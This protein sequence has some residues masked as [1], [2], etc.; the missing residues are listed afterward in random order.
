MNSSRRILLSIG[1]TLILCTALFAL[2]RVEHE[3]S[4]FQANG[5]PSCLSDMENSHK[6]RLDEIHFADG[7]K[8]NESQQTLLGLPDADFDINSQILQRH[9]VIVDSNSRRVTRYLHWLN[10]YAYHYAIPKEQIYVILA[11]TEQ[12]SVWSN[13]IVIMRDVFKSISISSRH[14]EFITSDN[15]GYSI[16]LVVDG[17]GAVIYSQNLPSLCDI[18]EALQLYSRSG[19]GI[20]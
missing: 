11:E 19:R 16:Q 15:N 20:N 10:S 8:L 4:S 7:Q 1:S 13:L 6:L 18:K 12:D 17:S 5:V 2:A 14:E 3:I 9:I